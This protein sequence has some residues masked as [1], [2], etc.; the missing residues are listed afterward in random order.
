MALEQHKNINLA[1]I[2]ISG[3]DRD[4]WTYCE[5]MAGRSIQMLVDITP[6]VIRHSAGKFVARGKEYAHQATGNE[7][8]GVCPARPAMTRSY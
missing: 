7:P 6:P 4:I 1:L 8:S 5:K 3:F 2:D